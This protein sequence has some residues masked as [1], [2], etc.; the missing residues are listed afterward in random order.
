MRHPALAPEGGQVQA[1]LGPGGPQALRG[2]AGL[3][4]HLPPGPREGKLQA[5][6]AQP[7][8]NLLPQA[9]PPL[10]GK[11]EEA[12]KVPS[13]PVPGKPR[14]PPRKEEG[15]GRAPVAGL[16][17]LPKEAKPGLPLALPREGEPPPRLPGEGEAEG[18][19][20]GGHLGEGEA[21]RPLLQ[22]HL[23]PGVAD[24]EERPFPK[25]SPEG[26]GKLPVDPLPRAL[27]AEP[28]PLEASPHLPR[29]PQE[30]EGKPEAPPVP[31]PLPLE[32]KG[33]LEPVADP[34]RH[35]H[36]AAEGQRLQVGHPG[37]PRKPEAEGPPRA[38][39]LPFPLHGH[40]ARPVAA[41]KAQGKPL[42]KDLPFP[43][44]VGAFQEEAGP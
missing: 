19:G 21:H 44:Q 40:P 7:P 3:Q 23:P 25:T 36:L 24:L 39:P 28:L 15:E 18:L 20:Q 14:L 35:L 17:G 1:G 34:V 9:E 12:L 6:V 42:R 5:P 32:G 41:G 16:E 37:L 27:Q 31:R 29:L 33:T 22:G 8:R 4:G 26:E 13:P 43:L 11:P 10:P 2:E 30:G 38:S